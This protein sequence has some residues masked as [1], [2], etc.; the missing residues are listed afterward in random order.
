[1][2]NWAHTKRIN[3][4][5]EVSAGQSAPQNSDAFSDTGIPFVRAGSLDALL[6][7]SN[8]DALEKISPDAKL[9]TS[10]RLFPKD[11]I[12]FAKSG[13]SATLG[14]VYRL[15][16][17]CYVVSH[18]AAIIPDKRVVYP[19]YLQRWFEKFPPSHLIPNQAY[20]SIRLSSISGLEVPLPDLAEQK[21]IA[22]IL[23]KAD[24][25][26]RK[27]QQ[28]LALTD[29]LL[30]STFLEMFGDPVTNPKGCKTMALEKIAKVERGRFSP[31]PRNDP[32]FYDGDYPF[33]Q[34]GDIAAAK[35]Y[36]N[37]WHQTLNDQGIRVSK[38]FDPGTVLVA[39]VGATIGETAIL[40]SRMYC[41][42]SVVGISPQK[43]ITPEYLEYL[44]RFWRPRFIASAPETARANINLQ[45]LKPLE[46]I[47]PEDSNLQVFT[48]L[49]K[50]A[51]ERF[52]HGSTTESDLFNSCL[53]RAFRGEL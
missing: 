13:M 37:T 7:G 40:C 20:P 45:T 16:K 53:Q 36:L 10:M 49:Y 51:H 28:A 14:R 12:L 44:L 42:D 19:A 33:V 9:K 26:R 24:A 43:L 22:A 39:I 18:L 47:I 52:R 25:I 38:G 48:N 46:V 34:T 29:D 15:K 30:R 6:N 31:R 11:T 3:A 27:R 35:G 41:P 2:S 8:E 32:R 50:K 21:R 17:D 1:M 5:A 23:D 4:I